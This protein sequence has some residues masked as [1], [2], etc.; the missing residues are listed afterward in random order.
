MRCSRG[1]IKPFVVSGLASHTTSPW[2]TLF[3]CSCVETSTH[4]GRVSCQVFSQRFFATLPPS[5][6]QSCAGLL[7]QQ[8]GAV[9]DVEGTE[10]PRGNL[11]P[12][13]A[14]IFNRTNLRHIFFM[15]PQ[16]FC[17]N[18]EFQLLTFGTGSLAHSYRLLCFLCLILPTLSFLITESTPK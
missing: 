18:I 7:C 15:V 1:Q 14:S 5:F 4:I 8:V 17:S 6:P 12:R 11:H 10:F 16:R 13:E 2:P 3:H 9:W